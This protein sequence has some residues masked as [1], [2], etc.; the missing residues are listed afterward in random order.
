MRIAKWIAVLVLIAAMAWAA[1]GRQLMFILDASNSMNEVVERRTTR[2]EW[3]KEALSAVIRDLDD[4]V[5][6]GIVVFGH[7][8][9]HTRP[10]ESCRDIELFVPYGRHTQA[11]REAMVRRVLGLTARGNTPLADSITYAMERAPEATRIVL[12]TDGRETCH[13]DKAA[14]ARRLAERGVLL[15]IVA[16]GITQDVQALLAD[17]AAITGGRFLMVDDPRELPEKF[18]EIA[19]TEPEP[20]P[21][22]EIPAAYRKYRVDAKII[23]L[24]LEHLPYHDCSPMWDVIFRFLERNP[25]DNVIVGS[26]KDDVLFGTPGNDLILGIGGRNLIYGMGGNDL[27]IG[28]PGDDV[29]QAGSGNNLLLGGAGNDLLVGGPGDDIIYGEEGNDRIESGPSGTNY[30][31]GGPGDDVILGGRGCNHIDPGPGANVVIDQGS[32]PSV[33]REP[34]PGDPCATVPFTPVPPSCAPTPPTCT[35]RPPVCTVSPVVKTVEEGRSIPLR[36]EVYDPDGDAVTVTWSAP[37]GHF[38]NPHALE[39]LYYAPWVTDCVSEDVEVTITAV[40]ACG[41]KARTTLIVRVLN[42]NHPPVVDAGPDLIIDEGKSVRMCAT[43][44][45]PDCGPL[46]YRWSAECGRGY[47]DDPTALNPIYTA[48][49]TDRCEGENVVLTLTVTDICGAVSKDSLVVHVRNINRPPWVDAGPDLTV[50]EGAQ[51][52]IL[53][54]AADPDGGPLTVRWTA[55]KGSFIGGDTLNPIFVAPHLPGCDPIDVLVKVRV[56]DRCGDW[57]EDTL[58]IRVNSVNHPPTIRIGNGG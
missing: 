9:P 7:R 43:A 30:L 13:G 10:E 14:A 28:G 39:T 36:A 27:L 49:H 48:P 25:P 5:P 12:L 29:I 57:A 50:C 42:V 44:Y 6:F 18:R 58:I 54:R 47:F 34:R 40:D 51:I 23:A 4:T 20:E 41:A 11:E 19:V 15:D 32:C 33:T 46:T 21:E 1:S 26:D 38:S 53:A 45:D 16:V 22:P 37:R 8:V 35:T 52:M 17:I 3:V 24:L 31:F 55:T 56:T 2:F